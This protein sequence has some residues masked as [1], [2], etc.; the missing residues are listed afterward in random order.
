MCW[1]YLSSSPIVILHPPHAR[2]RNESILVDSDPKWHAQIYHL[3]HC[4]NT[5]FCIPSSASSI[6]HTSLT[7]QEVLQVVPSTTH[8]ITMP[9]AVPHNTG[10]WRDDGRVF[11]LYTLASNTSSST[12]YPSSSEHSD[13]IFTTQ[14][15]F[16]YHQFPSTYTKIHPLKSTTKHSIQLYRKLF[17]NTNPI[18]PS[19]H[20]IHTQQCAAQDSPHTSSAVA[21]TGTKTFALTP[22]KPVQK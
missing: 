9:R 17:L 22:S 4:Q 18:R 10:T 8:G 15:L 16:S 5:G 20:P 13:W 19:N 12:T 3:F 7:R 21:S 14:R 2:S 6:P 11:W 1:M